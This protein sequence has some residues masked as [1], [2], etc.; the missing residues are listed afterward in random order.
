MTAQTGDAN[1][2]APALDEELLLWPGD[3]PLAVRPPMPNG[4]AR[5]R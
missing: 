3:E 1:G 2:P 5:S 4:F